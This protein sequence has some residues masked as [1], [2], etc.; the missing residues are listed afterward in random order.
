MFIITN[1]ISD[2]ND[3]ED[4]AII[5]KKYFTPIPK[6]FPFHKNFINGKIHINQREM[7]EEIEPCL[8][9]FLS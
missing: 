2:V 1:A 7:G 5:T 8:N 4:F 6:I 3:R 9:M